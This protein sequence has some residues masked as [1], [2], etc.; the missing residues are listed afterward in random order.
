[1]TLTTRDSADE[2]RDAVIYCDLPYEGTT[3]DQYGC[4]DFDFRHFW[5]WARRQKQ[6]YVS[7]TATKEDMTVIW[8]KLHTSK[9]S[10]TTST[11]R[12]ELLMIPEPRG[13]IQW[14]IF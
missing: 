3:C 10:G 8:D 2:L 11:K 12:H 1:M 7:D 5:Y 4:P 9:V 6:I 13:G 14:E